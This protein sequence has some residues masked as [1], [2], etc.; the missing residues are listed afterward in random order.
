MSLSRVFPNERLLLLTAPLCVNEWTLLRKRKQHLSTIYFKLLCVTMNELKIRNTLILKKEKY[1]SYT[2]SFSPNLEVTFHQP[3]QKNE[4]K[5]TE[6]RMW[7]R[8]VTDFEWSGQTRRHRQRSGGAVWQRVCTAEHKLK[9]PRLLS[10]T[11]SRPNLHGVLHSTHKQPLEQLCSVEER[12]GDARLAD[13][14]QQVPFHFNT[15]PPN[16]DKRWR[17]TR[18]GLHQWNGVS[19]RFSCGGDRPIFMIF[20][21]QI[22]VCTNIFSSLCVT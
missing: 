8:K 12:P 11:P 15:M 14:E 3:P 20:L 2:L 9:K 7:D 13:K 1:S 17:Q 4:R 16:C 19:H 6:E 10:H 22:W 5:V 21:K 18:R